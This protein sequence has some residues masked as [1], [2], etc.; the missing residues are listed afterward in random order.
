MEFSIKNVNWSGHVMKSYWLWSLKL[1]VYF[2]FKWFSIE[3]RAWFIIG[4]WLFHLKS[5]AYLAKRK[6]YTQLS[7]FVIETP[8]AQS[9]RRH[10]ANKNN[11]RNEAMST[12]LFRLYDYGLWAYDATIFVF[13]SWQRIVMFVFWICGSHWMFLLWILSHNCDHKLK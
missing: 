4:W 12:I 7:T 2:H 1:Q 13:L 8:R 6:L 10:E 11:L 3:I 5:F 9:I